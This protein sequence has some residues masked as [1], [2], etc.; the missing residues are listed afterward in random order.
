MLRQLSHCTDTQL[1]YLLARVREIASLGDEAALIETDKLVWEITEEEGEWGETMERTAPEQETPYQPGIPFQQQP[2]FVFE[3]RMDTVK[4][5]LRQFQGNVRDSRINH[6]VVLR[7]EQFLNE[8]KEF[9]VPVDLEDTRWVQLMNECQDSVNQV[10]EV[11]LTKTLGECSS[12]TFKNIASVT[13]MMTDLEQ[14]VGG[15]IQRHALT[16]EMK[17]MIHTAKERGARFRW[18]KKIADAG[19]AE[20]A[21][22]LGKAAG[23]RREA[24]AL[25][26]QDWAMVFPCEVPPEASLSA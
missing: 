2:A 24:E 7:F 3:R 26:V 20:R 6:W 13:S 1:E 14:T 5:W 15:Y 12:R 25:L 21:G 8:S 23:L 18:S 16:D 17:Q 19:V 10:W 22:Y 4:L 11:V 9:S